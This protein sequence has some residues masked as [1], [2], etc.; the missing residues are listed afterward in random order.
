[1]IQYDFDADMKF[2]QVLKIVTIGL[3]Q[4]PYRMGDWDDIWTAFKDFMFYGVIGPLFRLFLMMTLPISAPIFAF[5][6]QADRRKEAQYR[7]EARVRIA[8]LHHAQVIRP[9]GTSGTMHEVVTPTV[10]PEWNGP[11]IH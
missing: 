6:V 4:W 8:K 2:W 7:H 1:M 3:I 11:F 9:V 5:V 10:V